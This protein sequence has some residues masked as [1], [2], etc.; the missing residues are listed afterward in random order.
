MATVWTRGQTFLS[1][2]QNTLPH[3]LNPS[4]SGLFCWLF[5]PGWQSAMI[6]P[7][8][9]VIKNSCSL[10]LFLFLVREVDLCIIMTDWLFFVL[11]HPILQ[12]DSR[13]GCRLFSY[14]LAALS[15]PFSQQSS[16]LAPSFL[17]GLLSPALTTLSQF[18]RAQ[19]FCLI[20]VLPNKCCT[21]WTRTSLCP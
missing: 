19:S 4:I 18:L 12:Q 7:L 6:L 13:P 21:L 11:A 9:P 15:Q 20:P 1:A 17:F 10:S 16:G 5:S 3:C 14:V 2:S 8:V